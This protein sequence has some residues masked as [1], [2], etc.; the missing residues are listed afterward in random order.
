MG[1]GES[2][3]RAT[4]PATA[5]FQEKK[6]PT[7][8]GI[9]F[10]KPYFIY[11]TMHFKLERDPHTTSTVD[12]RLLGGDGVCDDGK[13]QGNTITAVGFIGIHHTFVNYSDC[14]VIRRCWWMSVNNSRKTTG[15]AI[16]TSGCQAHKNESQICLHLSLPAAMYKNMQY[17]RVALQRNS[18]FF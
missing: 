14:C 16:V 4:A 10:H 6:A 2:G 17:S 15:L 7:C 12:S 3:A 11:S 5:K 13:G 8:P 18:C 1:M 9:A